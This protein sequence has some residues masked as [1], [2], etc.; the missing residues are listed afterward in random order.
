MVAARAQQRLVGAAACPGCTPCPPAGRLAAAQGQP[1]ARSQRER[2]YAGRAAAHRSSLRAAAAR[3]MPRTRRMPRRPSQI[4]PELGESPGRRAN[5]AGCNWVVPIADLWRHPMRRHQVAPPAGAASTYSK[6]LAAQR[7]AS[8]LRRRTAGNSPRRRLSRST[9]PE[10]R[11]AGPQA[12]PGP[13]HA[14]PQQQ[15]YWGHRA[16]A[17]LAQLY[18]CRDSA[19]RRLRDQW[20]QRRDR[21][22][23]GAELSCDPDHATA[24]LSLYNHTSIVLK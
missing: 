4:E 5:L 16:T 21:R 22:G 19:V 7:S 12:G 17:S 6:Q 18:S 14:R 9:L 2:A 13:F 8:G 20:R 24:Y 11:A 15:R 3:P 23:D 10:T 1:A